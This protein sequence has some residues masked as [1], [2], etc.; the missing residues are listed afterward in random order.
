MFGNI[1]SL[2]ADENETASQQ[3]D[4]SA[5]ESMAAGE[6]VAH[7]LEEGRQTLRLLRESSRIPRP[8][9]EPSR[10]QDGAVGE[11]QADASMQADQQQPADAQ[12]QP[13]EAEQAVEPAQQPTSVEEEQ[14]PTAEHAL[15]EMDAEQAPAQPSAGADAPSEQPTQG[16]GEQQAASSRRVTITIRGE[17]ID[18]TDSGIDPEFLEALPDDLRAEVVEQHLRERRRAN[19][20]SS[21][22]AE[23][24]VPAEEI[25]E[26]F[27]DA[28]PPEIREEVLEQQRMRQPLLWFCREAKSRTCARSHAYRRHPESPTSTGTLVCWVSLEK[29]VF[30]DILHPI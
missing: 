7:V 9:Q 24:H 13:M 3:H 12:Q 1:R 19:Q 25:S 11:N 17:E 2:L 15:Q 8:I 22:T 21:V 20:G 6:L 27:L 18:L 26:E 23:V 28:L 16:P 30:R 29:L 4:A 10:A 14:Q 5:V